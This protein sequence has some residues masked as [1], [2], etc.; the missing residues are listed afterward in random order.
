M[1]FRRT[2]TPRATLPRWEPG[3][4]AP[5]RGHHRADGQ[6]SG[7]RWGDINY[8]LLLQRQFASKHSCSSADLSLLILHPCSSR[9]TRHQP[10]NSF[11]NIPCHFRTQHWKAVSSAWDELSCL[12]LSCSSK[13]G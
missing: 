13:S 2:Q 4:P 12:F 6:T 8:N 10:A 7:S 11:L 1:L 9:S 3:E 5:P